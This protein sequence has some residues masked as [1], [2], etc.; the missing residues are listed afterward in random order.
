[1]SLRA[2]TSA[3]IAVITVTSIRLVVVAV[4]IFA[5]F[6]GLYLFEHRLQ[7]VEPHWFA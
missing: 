5:P 3:A 4:A 7:G 2:V 1:M 6:L